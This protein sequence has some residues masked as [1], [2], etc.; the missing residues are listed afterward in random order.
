MAGVCYS[1]GIGVENNLIKLVAAAILVASVVWFL[2]DPNAK[3]PKQA[4]VAA[5][6][7]VEDE[8][9]ADEEEESA[10]DESD[11]ISNSMRVEGCR[12]YWGGKLSCSLVNMGK[13]EVSS[14]SILVSASEDKPKGGKQSLSGRQETFYELPDNLQDFEFDVEGPFAA[15]KTKTIAVMLPKE[16]QQFDRRVKILN[17]QF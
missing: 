4:P 9:T 13:L 5:V 2:K 10:P 14:I 16:I 1:Q 6:E 7:D 8:Y 15:G 17:A 3:V 11:Y 12:L